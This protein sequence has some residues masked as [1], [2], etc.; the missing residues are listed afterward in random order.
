[1]YGDR[2]SPAR[3]FTGT[4]CSLGIAALVLSVG[5]FGNCVS[6]GTPEACNVRAS[7]VAVDAAIWGLILVVLGGMCL[8]LYDCF[9]IE[10]SS[11]PHGARFETPTGDLETRDE[12]A[13][14]MLTFGNRTGGYQLGSS[15]VPTRQ[16]G[17]TQPLM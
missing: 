16:C 17:A 4:V 2:P 15:K 12:E 9:M 6:H 5:F 10:P 11:A 14:G 8:A 1:M 7:F 3:C 13:I